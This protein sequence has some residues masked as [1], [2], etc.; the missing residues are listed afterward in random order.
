ME[1]VV[2]SRSRRRQSLLWKG[3][4][5]Q[6]R[7]VK[8]YVRV[9]DLGLS[10]RAAEVLKA[11]AGTRY[12]RSSDGVKLVTSEYADVRCMRGRSISWNCVR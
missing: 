8:L 7:T 1:G 10:L 6:E 11:I 4:S 3:S 9:R 2:T 5:Y 12:N